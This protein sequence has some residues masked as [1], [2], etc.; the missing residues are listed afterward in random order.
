M[1]KEDKAMNKTSSAGAFS[2][3]GPASS[4]LPMMGLAQMDA[5]LE[6]QSKLFRLVDD[7]A[8][9]WRE[10]V[11]RSAD[12]GTNMAYRLRTAT[13]PEAAA[14]CS[15]WMQDSAVRYAADTKR[16]GQLW[17][18]FCASAA[19]PRGVQTAAE[20]PIVSAGAQKVA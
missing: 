7:A 5:V 3:G 16:I 10:S 1:N 11:Q 14:L 8:K 9:I 17:G 2:I 18:D 15:S 13:P 4:A 20:Q 19:T 12:A 6:A